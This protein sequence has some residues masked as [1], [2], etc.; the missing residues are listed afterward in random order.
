MTE[1]EMVGWHHQLNGHEREQTLGE[2][3]GQGSLVCCSPWGCRVRYDLAIEQDYN[4]VVC[5]P[6]YNNRTG[7]LLRRGGEETHSHTEAGPRE[8]TGEDSRPLAKGRC[9][10]RNQPVKTGTS[11]FSL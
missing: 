3:E 8:D 10:K 6:W 5:V 4:E 7:V 9:L 2:S 11:D 1:D